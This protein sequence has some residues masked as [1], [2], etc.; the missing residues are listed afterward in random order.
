MLNFSPV[1]QTLEIVAWLANA[2]TIEGVD[3]LLLMNDNSQP[4]SNNST[5][6]LQ[7]PGGE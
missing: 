4:T 2:V 6:L 1:L 3:F 7:M 5:N